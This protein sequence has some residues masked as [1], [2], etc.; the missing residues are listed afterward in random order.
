MENF[1]KKL[2]ETIEKIRSTPAA[3]VI[4][5]ATASSRTIRGPVTQ[6]H[7]PVKSSA[8]ES[9]TSVVR[10]NFALGL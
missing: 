2:Q 4:T 1:T 10:T 3:K 9:K 8:V 7:A 6:S 5:P